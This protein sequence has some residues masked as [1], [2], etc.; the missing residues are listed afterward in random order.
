MKPGTAAVLGCL[1]VLGLSIAGI[2]ALGVIGVVIATREEP[3]PEVLPAPGPDQ[4]PR[5]GVTPGPEP[6]PSKEPDRY[7]R[8]VG[9]IGGFARGEEP[10]A[11][12]LDYRF[13][14]YAGQTREIRCRV[15]RADLDAAIAGY[16]LNPRRWAEVNARLQA[17]L[18]A[19]VR[20][21]ALE[22][23]FEAE[24]YGRGAWRWSWKVPAG[25]DAGEHARAV[26]ESKRLHAHLER[27][28]QQQADR[29][30]DRALRQWG[31]RV[32]GD[33]LRVDHQGVVERATQPLADCTAALSAL[34]RDGGVRRALG[35]VLAFYQEL[36]YELPQDEPGRELIGLW[37]PAEVLV[38]GAGD[39][40]SKSL[41]FC[42]SWR[43]FGTRSIVVLVPKHALVGVEAPPGPGERFV[44]LGNRYFVLA[45]PAGPA[46][47]A[48]GVSDVE[49]DFEYVMIEPLSGSGA[50]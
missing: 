47:L 39:C 6:K 8:N 12:R 2:V 27:D 28:F 31:L 10:G 23:Y 24:A 33:R 40:D 3:A 14:D 48:P 50:P 7:R 49:G 38:R 1:G 17:A 20:E 4:P 37:P 19:L 44:R 18:D 45:E 30:E 46:K 13:V 21:R 11:Y 9:A 26:R 16:G 36:R 29:I 22:A 42:A 34:A 5:P 32:D 43:R 35:I 41:A 15:A 25:T